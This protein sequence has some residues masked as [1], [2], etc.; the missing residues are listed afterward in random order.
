MKKSS[1]EHAIG[2]SRP[3]KDLLKQNLGMHYFFKLNK[4]TFK[5]III[6]KSIEIKR[7]YLLETQILILRI[8][9]TQILKYLTFQ[10]QKINTKKLTVSHTS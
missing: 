7:F 10:Q 2:N 9:S 8:S 5:I 1:V 4:Q 3:S 6:K